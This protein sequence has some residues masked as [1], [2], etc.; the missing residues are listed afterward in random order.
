MS[1]LG[2]LD[3]EKGSSQAIAQSPDDV[4]VDWESMPDRVK[5]G[6]RFVYVDNFEDVLK[7]CRSWRR[8][9]AER[10]R[11]TRSPLRHDD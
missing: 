1:L 9:L 8:I 7:I 2:L 6:I 4:R 11:R 5:E 10:E 3:W